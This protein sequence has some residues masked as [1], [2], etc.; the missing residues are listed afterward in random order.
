MNEPLKKVS[1]E[2]ETVDLDFSCGEV[3]KNDNN[4]DKNRKVYGREME[5]ILYHFSTNFI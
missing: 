4:G 1:E 3:L 5:S 2:L